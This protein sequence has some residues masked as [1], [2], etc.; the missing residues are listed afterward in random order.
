MEEKNRNKGNVSL[1]I[2]YIF[3]FSSFLSYFPPDLNSPADTDTVVILLLLLLLL[4]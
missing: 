2:C 1:K 3:T 4:N